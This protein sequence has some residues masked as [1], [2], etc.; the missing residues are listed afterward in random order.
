MGLR[1]ISIRQCIRRQVALLE[2]RG[3]ISR[4]HSEKWGIS[5]QSPSRR[6]ESSQISP[7]VYHL[8][9][10]CRFIFSISYPSPRLTGLYALRGF[11]YTPIPPTKPGLTWPG[12]ARAREAGLRRFQGVAYARRASRS[13]LQSEEVFAYERACCDF[14]R[15]LDFTRLIGGPCPGRSTNRDSATH[16]LR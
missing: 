6:V 2:P 9:G 14:S 1:G 5:R 8:T 15:C 4:V 11:C 3:P 7:H 12:P 16:A 10:V 13:V